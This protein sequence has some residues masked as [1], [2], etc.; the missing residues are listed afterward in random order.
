MH[1]IN[2]H[3]AKTQKMF[4][5]EATGCN[6]GFN[7]NNEFTSKLQNAYMEFTKLFEYNNCM[8]VIFELMSTSLFYGVFTF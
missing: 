2:L 5:P 1:D 3:M 4:Q 6:L 8:V 7:P